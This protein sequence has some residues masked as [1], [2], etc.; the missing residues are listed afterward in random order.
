MASKKYTL[1]AAV[2]VFFQLTSIAQTKTDWGWDWKD[3]SKVPTKSIPQY[4]EFL[5]NQ[6]PYPP[7]PKSAWEL[8]LSV[9]NGLIVGDRPLFVK[10]SFDH[11]YLG[12]ITA[13]LSLR[14]AVGHVLS[15]RAS[16]NYTTVTI[17]SYKA[18]TSNNLP[19]STVK[20][21]SVSAS[22]DALFSLNAASYYRGNPK[23]DWYLLAGY[24]LIATQIKTYQNGSY[25]LANFPDQ[26]TAGTIQD[27]TLIHGFDF[28]TGVAFKISPK[29]NIGLE[30][31]FTA[32]VFGN[33]YLDGYKVPGS[34]NGDI[35][36]Y[37]TIRLNFN[38][39]N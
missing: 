16:A 36:S 34:K 11:N 4:N 33:D 8:G 13:G 24:S 7:K 6:F 1:L 38:L 22:F 39:G 3:S 23:T 5:N 29:F 19:F 25:R 17:P 28:G 18:N 35:F 15:L 20:N 9:G 32:P 30:Q 31:K 12:G 37:S 26:K 10:N 21:N 14:K 27:L 2:L